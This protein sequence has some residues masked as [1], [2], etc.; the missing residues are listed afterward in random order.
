MPFR[1]GGASLA[2]VEH[3]SAALP[4]LQRLFSRGP[5]LRRMRPLYESVV[6]EA[7]DPFW[8]EAGVPDTIDGRFDMLAAILALVL[9]RLDREGEAADRDGV[10]LFE[11]FVDDMDGTIRQIG[12]GDFV[13]GKH[14]GR[15]VGALGGRLEAFRGDVGP[16]VLRNIF[17]EAPPGEDALAAVSTRLSG[18]R[19]SIARVPLERLLEGQLK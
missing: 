17:H 12:I 16:A 19:D 1:A 11:T 8:Y 5:D 6:A 15:M 7:R 4:L 9:N 13:V 14:V 3:R 2:L 10:L 18:L